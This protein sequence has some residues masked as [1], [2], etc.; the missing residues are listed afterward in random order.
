MKKEIFNKTLDRE[1]S[2]IQENHPLH[3]YQKLIKAK[4]NKSK[5]N[6]YIGI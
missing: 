1:L 6:T 5:E 3:R 4:H 2:K